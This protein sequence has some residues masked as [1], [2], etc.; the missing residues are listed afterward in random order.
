VIGEAAIRTS[1]L[2]VGFAVASPPE[3]EPEPGEAAPLGCSAAHT[4]R[5]RRRGRRRKEAREE[6]AKQRDGGGRSLLQ[7][8]VEEGSRR[9][10][11]DMAAAAAAAAR[12]NRIGEKRRKPSANGGAE[13]IRGHTAGSRTAASPTKPFNRTSMDGWPINFLNFCLLLFYSDCCMSVIDFNRNGE[14]PR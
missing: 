4:R 3:P 8:V 14:F 2:L 1:P 13:R 10:D 5:M 7:V 11:G 9:S 12:V 6:E